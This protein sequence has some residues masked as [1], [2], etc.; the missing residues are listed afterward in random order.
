MPGFATA[1]VA[2]R[3]VSVPATPPQF[4]PS[5]TA[6]HAFN[7]FLL[8]GAAAVAVALLAIDP[9]QN[10]RIS[11]VWTS[12]VTLSLSLSALWL[13]VHWWAGVG[14]RNLE[15]L[16]YSYTTLILQYSTFKPT[17]DR[18]WY[19]SKPNP[20]IDPPGFYPSPNKP[21]NFELWTGSAWTGQYRSLRAPETGQH[22]GIAGI[23][24]SSSQNLDRST[25]SSRKYQIDTRLSPTSRQDAA[26]TGV[27]SSVL[28]WPNRLPEPGDPRAAAAQANAGGSTVPG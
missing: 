12:L 27:R 18:R 8:K 16:R 6:H 15:E 3:L 21:E 28:S 14:A 2:D 22:F 7:L 23:A 20:D 24:S 26:C 19:K 13:I 1:A 5:S 10:L 4:I 25:V 17:G 11:P 9:I